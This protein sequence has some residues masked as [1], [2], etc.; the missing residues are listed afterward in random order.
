[1]HISKWQMIYNLNKNILQKWQCF[2]A[3]AHVNY[4]VLFMK[5]SFHSIKLKQWNLA[6]CNICKSLH[7]TNG[8]YENLN[9]TKSQ[10]HYHLAT[11]YSCSYVVDFIQE[12]CMETDLH[13]QISQ[14]QASLKHENFTL[15]CHTT[16]LPQNIL[17]LQPNFNC[18][19]YSIN[20][21]R[22]TKIRVSWNDELPL[23]FLIF[24]TFLTLPKFELSC[25]SWPN[26]DLGCCN[27]L[28][29]L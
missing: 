23:Q 21:L 22:F 27:L 13:L 10:L 8:K 24:K 6:G 3:L 7:E 17:Q 2:T 20:N 28:K 5:T 4:P 29:Y 25:F 14:H 9:S 15:S 11:Y 18:T 1:M 26:F 16:L 12:Y 19:L